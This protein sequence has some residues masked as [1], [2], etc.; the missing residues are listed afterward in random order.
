M[1]FQKKTEEDHGQSSSSE[2]HTPLAPVFVNQPSLP[3]RKPTGL[4]P[5]A[6]IDVGINI[7]GCLQTE[8]EVQVDGQ[9]NGDV[10]C[11]HLTVGKTG[12]IIGDVSADEVVVRGK[13]KGV[14]RAGRVIIQEG[15]HVD[16]K[17][18]V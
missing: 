2:R 7:L 16:R 15:A 12:I 1:L 5:R 13:L 14:I 18:V 17:S 3:Q 11:G 8:G 10:R 9:I 4:P 6:V